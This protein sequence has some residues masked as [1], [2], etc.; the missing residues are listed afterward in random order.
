MLL[1][2]LFGVV[3]GLVVGG[4]LGFGLVQIWPGALPAFMAYVA[5]PLAGVIVGLIAGKP[6]WAEGGKIEAGLKAGAGAVLGALL[7]WG[8]RALLDG[9]SLAPFGVA[10]AA[11][12]S[13]AITSLALV[14][15]T[16][17]AFYDA[18]NT[19]EPAEASADGKGTPKLRVAAPASD[20]L[21]LDLEEDDASAEEKQRKAKR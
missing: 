20:D 5:A 14:A 9:V 2:L 10:D 21:D 4:L 17:G 3:K 19:P 1:R 18:D 12:G 7:M 13:W 8:T 15:A 16:L 6:I 11:L